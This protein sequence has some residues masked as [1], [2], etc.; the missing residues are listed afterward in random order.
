[1]MDT[2]VASPWS[3]T[4]MSSKLPAAY[5]SRAANGGERVWQGQRGPRMAKEP[6]LGPSA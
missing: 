6:F 5:A 4:C 3:C 2:E 1:M